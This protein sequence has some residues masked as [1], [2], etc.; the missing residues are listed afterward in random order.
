MLSGS[1]QI[2]TGGDEPL[3]RESEGED[4]ED[5]EGGEDP[6]DRAW[7]AHHARGRQSGI[8]L[9]NFIKF[10]MLRTLCSHDA[11]GLPASKAFTD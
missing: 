7:R 10:K 3:D 6:L 9:N 11:S 5:K 4:T 2:C 8:Y 1:R